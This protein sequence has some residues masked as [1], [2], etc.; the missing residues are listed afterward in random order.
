MIEALYESN[1]PELTLLARGKVRDLY[2]ID[3]ETLLFV[4]T[5]RI[6]AYDVIM[7]SPV[8]GKGKILTQ[9]SVFWFDF[10]KDVVPNHLITADIDEMPAVVQ[11]YRGQLKG[12]SLLVRKVQVLPV[13]AIVRGFIT[14]SG[15]KEYQKSGSVCGIPLPDGLRESQKLPKPLFT[16]STKAE[17]GEHDENIHPDKCAELIGRAQT[18]AMSQAALELYSR[19][20]EYAA[21]KGI[22]IADTKFEFG[23]DKDG[24]LMLIDEALTPDSSRFWPSC[25]YKVGRG[26]ES[27]DKQYLRDYL[28]SIDFDNTTP[29]DLPPTVLDNTF[30]KYIEAYVKLTASRPDLS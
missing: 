13:E 1:C 28:T 26:Q 10:L 16:P 17:Y 12:R 14:G 9:I 3:D 8:A 30:K 20:A 29:I 23:V 21:G 22:I 25:S 19:A 15:W 4:A 18:D 7:K 5:D 11:Q 6:S 27:Y 24:R 2:D